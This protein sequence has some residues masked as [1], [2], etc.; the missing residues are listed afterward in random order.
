MRSQT[1]VARNVPTRS[2]TA[3]TRLGATMVPS[4]LTQAASSNSVIIL[5]GLFTLRAPRE[6]KSSALGGVWCHSMIKLAEWL[7]SL[8]IETQ[9]RPR[10]GCL[11]LDDK[12]YFPCSTEIRT[13][14]SPS[15]RVCPTN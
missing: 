14:V 11:A 6:N 13:Q 8:S 2:R 10:M 9:I 7:G 4:A 15:Q 3:I 12:P 5:F 1:P